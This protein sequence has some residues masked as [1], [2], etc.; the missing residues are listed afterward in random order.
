MEAP[1]H[2][3]GHLG[4]LRVHI[5]RAGM[6]GY[7]GKKA[8]REKKCQQDGNNH[9]AASYA[10]VIPSYVPVL[11]CTSNSHVQVYYWLHA[12]SASDPV[13]SFKLM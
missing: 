10:Y 11:R 8:V 3:Q 2:R 6:G 1:Q 12:P 9:A 4:H 7:L 5:N 13:R